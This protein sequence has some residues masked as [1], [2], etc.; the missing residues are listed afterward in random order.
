[1]SN[2]NCTS[3]VKELIEN[4]KGTP[5]G[6]EV[7]RS[8]KGKPQ[9]I[10]F[11]ETVDSF[12]DVIEDDCSNADR[13]G[14]FADTPASEGGAIAACEQYEAD[15]APCFSVGGK[16]KSTT[17]LKSRLAK[18]YKEKDSYEEYED[19]K[20]KAL[21]VEQEKEHPNIQKYYTSIASVLFNGD[22]TVSNY[23]TKKAIKELSHTAGKTL[24][25]K[26]LIDD[27]KRV[28]KL[29]REFESENEIQKIDSEIK[30][31]SNESISRNYPRI[32]YLEALRLEL[33]RKKEKEEMKLDDL[34]EFKDDLMNHLRGK[35]KMHKTKIT[36]TG[37]YSLSLEKPTKKK[38]SKPVKAKKK[39][40]PQKQNSIPSEIFYQKTA[41]GKCILHLTK[42]WY[43]KMFPQYQKQ[44][45]EYFK[46]NPYEKNWKCKKKGAE[47][48]LS[49]LGIPERNSEPLRRVTP[50]KVKQEKKKSFSLSS[51]SRSIG[52]GVQQQLG[53]SFISRLE[54]LEHNEKSIA[55]VILSMKPQIDRIESDVEVI[56]QI[57]ETEQ[58]EKIAIRNYDT[59]QEVF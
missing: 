16:I 56:K 26:L 59:S 6:V 5:Y 27:E 10:S 31:L 58:N 3:S 54:R 13:H 1:M 18:K 36:K 29:L 44:I 33:L 20:Y 12:K 11:N 46:W 55:N 47:S 48:V 28:L 23:T 24:L 2:N 30:K 50:E 42:V 51:E 7:R 17:V 14:R 53:L 37:K 32:N 43:N 4:V 22:I 45:K 39:P 25:T 19:N 34:K 49:K 57:V 9:A 41:D 40:T 8:K 21:N 52:Q 35:P 15:K 38:K